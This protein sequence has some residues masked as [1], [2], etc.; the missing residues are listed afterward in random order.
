MNHNYNPYYYGM[1]NYNGYQP[2]YLNTPQYPNQTMYPNLNQLLV[3][4]PYQEGPASQTRPPEWY[5][6]YAY[7][8][9]YINPSNV[10]DIAYYMNPQFLPNPR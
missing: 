6:N 2:N 7:A 4:G 9:P 8:S 5:Q 1:A 10:P 3:Y